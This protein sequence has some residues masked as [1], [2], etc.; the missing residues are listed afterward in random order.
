MFR[1]EVKNWKVV[2]APNHSVKD[3]GFS[4]TTPEEALSGDF[5]VLDATVPGNL[6]LDMQ[7]A[8]L[9]NDP[10]YG[11]NS[12]ETQRLE[13]RHLW[14]CTEFEVQ[15]QENCDV[16]LNFDGIDTVSEIYIDGK[17]CKKT[18][19]MFLEYSIPLENKTARHSLLVHVIPV[20]IHSRQ[21][22][23]GADCSALKYNFE[24]IKVRKA[25]YSYG[26]DI[27]PRIVSAGIWR[28]VYLS[29]LPKDRIEDIFFY[30][31]ELN[32]SYAVNQIVTDLHIT[33]D[34]L[35]D[36]SLCV[37]LENDEQ[38]VTASQQL[39]S[40]FS[41]IKLRLDDPK[42][43]MPKNY[44]E[45]NLYKL[46]VTLKLKEKILDEKTVKVGIRIT[47]LLRTSHAGDDGEF[48]FS[49]NGQKIFC[50]GTN[51]VPTDAFPSR[52]KA[53]DLRALEMAEDLGCNMLR[54][55]GGG[56]YPDKAVYDYCDSHGIMIWQDFAMGC[57]KY[58]EDKSFLSAL[59]QEAI[60][61]V[62][63]FR[64]HPSLVIW[65]GDNECDCFSQQKI[66]LNGRTVYQNDPNRYPGTRHTIPNVLK[67]EDFTRPYLPSSPYLDETV[68]KN[69][70]APAENHLW[71][72]RD[73]FKGDFY[74]KT[75]CH[76][77]SE[78]GYHGCNSPRSLERFIDKDKINGFS[79][80]KN[81]LDPQWIIHSAS[82]E[83]N[84]DSPYAYRVPLMYSQV[85]RLF[86][87]ACDDI[88]GFARQSQISQAEAKK[89]FIERFR[90]A[91][92]KK[93]GIL[94][95]NLIDGWPQIS[96]A[97]VDYYGIK[98]LAY[99]YVKRSQKPFCIMCDEPQDQKLKLVAVNDTQSDVRVEYTVT[100]LSSGQTLSSQCTVKANSNLTISSLPDVK[101]GFYHITW[102]G[103]E[104]GENHYTPAIY[105][106][107]SYEKYIENMKKA[108]FF[109]S[110]E[111]F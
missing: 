56:I 45:P 104:T 57:G 111:G 32:D 81:E 13:N 60:Q 34:I 46:T 90:I 100:E 80:K 58:P 29:Y 83:A 77:A 92:W 1:T 95:W 51:W 99:S 94:W 37:S 110:F 91:K 85:Q 93:T 10:Y 79:A 24:S 67:Q 88:D 75:P 63:R 78:T 101:D 55:W 4:P 39:F 65:A 72:P 107:L 20:M 23:L 19:N 22:R 12:I 44:G 52:N 6:E 5:T 82:A 28:D 40:V 103:D 25:A 98:K 68:V 35:Q 42:L 61:I 66:K 2:I 50:L 43:W 15:E 17:L 62:K 96:D 21:L 74:T 38:R 41:R 30:T 33:G 70:L 59:E 53:Y 106:G 26:W 109:D 11:T 9:L 64:N 76:F 7:K 97:V 71:G 16:F 3:K 8:G 49:V 86:G 89:F 14:Y 48:V 27:F 18:D 102:T 84:S 87:S 36:Y 47:E 108:G 54:M 31:C 73:F 105:Q 69:K